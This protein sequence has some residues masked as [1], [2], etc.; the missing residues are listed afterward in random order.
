[1]QV[2]IDDF[3]TGFTSVSQ[4]LGMP[5]DTLKIDRSFV[6]SSH[7]T[8]RELVHLM[9]RAAHAFGLRVVAEGVEEAGQIANLAECAVEA[10]QGYHFA[11]PQSADEAL[12]L[13]R[14]PVL[15]VRLAG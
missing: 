7:P 10:A 4:L 11:R 5:I 13:I 1:V 6:A 14:M 15:P 3:G 2:A 8:S 9:T 12:A